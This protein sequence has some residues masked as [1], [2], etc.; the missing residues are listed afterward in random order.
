MDGSATVTM[1]ASS[2]TISCAAEMRMSAAVRRGE[3]SAS[4]AAGAGD[5]SGSMRSALSAVWGRHGR[6]GHSSREPRRASLLALSAT[7]GAPPTA[8]I[9]DCCEL[10]AGSPLSLVAQRHGWP[11]VGGHP[12]PWTVLVARHRSIVPDV[13]ALPPQGI[14]LV[15]SQAPR[16]VHPPATPRLSQRSA[17]GS[18]LTW[19]YE[20]DSSS[21]SPEHL[22]EGPP[23]LPPTAERQE[24]RARI[25]LL[26]P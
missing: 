14:S 16:G 12:R 10:M 19:D 24:S 17:H 5:L 22:R 13:G 6:T 2:T 4:P 8:S 21:G 26:T 3:F 20:L 23:V 15:S 7:G 1:V 18:L 25:V 11:P 9:P